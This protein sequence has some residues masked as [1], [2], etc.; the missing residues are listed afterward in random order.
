MSHQR[1]KDVI[2]PDPIDVRRSAN[3]GKSTLKQNRLAEARKLLSNCVVLGQ[4]IHRLYL[5]LVATCNVDGIFRCIEKIDD[6][7]VCLNSFV[8]V[9]TSIIIGI[10]TK[11]CNYRHKSHSYMLQ[12][13]SHLMTKSRLHIVIHK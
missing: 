4:R 3:V 13:Y 6:N 8:N 5:L 9:T 11:I 12:Y 10:K 1:T 7:E 2:I